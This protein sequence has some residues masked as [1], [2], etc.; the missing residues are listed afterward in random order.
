MTLGRAG[1]GS[2]G[3]IDDDAMAIGSDGCVRVAVYDDG[4]VLGL[5]VGKATLIEA[6]EGSSGLIDDRAMTAGTRLETRPVWLSE[7]LRAPLSLTREEP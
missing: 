3:L 1:E 6:A 4:T 5:E 2:G 7:H